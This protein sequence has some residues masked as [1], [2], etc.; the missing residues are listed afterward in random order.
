MITKDNFIEKLKGI[1]TS[2]LSKDMQDSINLI[3]RATNNGTDWKAL[4]VESFRAVCEIVF[5]RLHNI[6]RTSAADLAP[7]NTK[8]QSGDEKDAPED[9]P[10]PKGK[11][12]RPV[13]PETKPEVQSEST[14]K[15]ESNKRGP[16]KKKSKEIVPEMAAGLVE[17]IP[18]EIRFMRR[19]VNMEG[20][21]KSKEDFR[22]FIAALQRAIYEKRIRKTSA[23]AKEIEYIQDKLV[24]TMKS[25]S[26]PLKVKITDQVL[27]KFREL[28][29]MERVMPS[30]NFIKR[31]VSLNGKTGIKGRAQVLLNA[32]TKAFDKGL[33]TKQDKYYKIFDVLQKNLSRYLKNKGQGAL[34]IEPAELSGLNGILECD[35]L[36]TENKVPDTNVNF[37]ENNTGVGVMTPNE[38]KERQYQHVNVGAIWQKLIGQFS[39]PTS[40]FIYGMGGSG[41]SSLAL[42]FMQHLSLLGYR[43]LYVAG[44]QF[45]TPPFK[46]LLIRLN[47]SGGDNFKIVDKFDRLNPKDFDFVVLDSKDSLEIEVEQFA[48]IKANYPKQSFVVIP[49]ATKAGSFRGREQWRNLVDVV[50]HCK[51]GIA[52]TGNGEKNRWGGRGEVK[53]YQLEPVRRAA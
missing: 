46:E 21:T 51:E 24:T 19:F 38:A 26:R 48:Q 47:I 43:I 13:E 23:Y 22:N 53:I 50:I 33:I 1:D 14:K 12:T 3:L 35:C 32:M 5:D 36:E 40:F 25:M 4:E 9:K 42:L 45:D 49:H 18:E 11:T 44:E 52:R 28:I 7:A 27:E 15:S 17:R 41:K 39:L 29:S 16:Y 6:L 8:T 30:I 20:K 34:V 10:V 37:A 2:K 31:Y